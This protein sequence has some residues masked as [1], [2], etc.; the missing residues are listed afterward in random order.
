MLLSGSIVGGYLGAH[1]AIAR[2]NRVV[3]RA[4]EVLA[5]LMGSSLLLKSF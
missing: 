2:G 3:K 5:L 1:L 4:F